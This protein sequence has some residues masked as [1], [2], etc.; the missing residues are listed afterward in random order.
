MKALWTAM[1]LT[2]LLAGCS[3]SGP[4]AAKTPPA[5][6][7]HPVKEN[8]LNTVVLSVEAEQRLGL[9]TAKVEKRA[10]KRRR[11]YCG[12]ITLPP[13]AV[14]A[15]AAPVTGRLQVPNG[16][17]LPAAGTVVNKDQPLFAL[18]PHV[19]TQA[20]RVG[21]AQA[22][23]ALAQAGIDA[24]AQL[25][26]A[27]VQLEAAQINF[28]R[29]E[30]LFREGVGLKKDLDD[31]IAQM[32]LAQKVH[33][34]AQAR[35]KF[36]DSMELDTEAGS[37]K[38]LTIPAPR[39]GI[40]RATFGVA[41]QL[42]PGGAA[43]FEIMDI[44][45]VWVR[46]PV[47]VGEAAQIAAAQPARV[48]SLADAPGDM[49]VPA[50]PVK[51]PPTAQAQASAVDFY[52]ELANKQHAYRPGE[53]V[54]ALLT[55][56]ADAESLAVP[57]SAVIHDIHGG[58]WVYVQTAERTYARRRVQ[59][60]YVVDDWAVLAEGPPAGTPIVT[61]GAAELFGTEFGFGK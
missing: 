3:R 56:Q 5:T 49:G 48:S 32:N 20:E 4:P 26:Q 24:E 13:D 57:W 37:I 25:K 19:L 1:L 33:D 55:L 8:D 38:P 6:V 12:E 23:L 59:V 14:Q 30:R 51:A 36:V 7:A 18:V 11:V 15:V 22:K 2:C 54:S 53:R 52:Y 34:A 60:R 35:K 28:K 50:R 42:V 58:A 45:T 31:A 47:Y 43:L 40:V 29:A 46:V 41:G 39:T 21:L 9:Q 27:T 17:K 61:E 10:V 16:G 44:D